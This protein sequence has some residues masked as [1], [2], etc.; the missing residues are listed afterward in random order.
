M[1]MDVQQVQSMMEVLESL[2]DIQMEVK[3]YGNRRIQLILQS[4]M[5]SSTKTTNMLRDDPRYHGAKFS[6]FADA[7]SVLQALTSG[8]DCSRHLFY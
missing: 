5:Y 8:D 2:S 4:T 6:S 1:M 7:M 3:C